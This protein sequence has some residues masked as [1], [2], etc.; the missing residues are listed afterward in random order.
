M[1]PASDQPANKWLQSSAQFIHFV[2]QKDIY[3]NIVQQKRPPRERD[4][5][6]NADTR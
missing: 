6:D 5:D 3:F 2:R 1:P 4:D